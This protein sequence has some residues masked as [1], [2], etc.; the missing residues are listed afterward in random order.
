MLR[1]D[2]DPAD[3][4]PDVAEL[5]GIGI[6]VAV[7]LRLTAT[8]SPEN[9]RDAFWV[10]NVL[11]AN[12]P[13]PPEPVP[14][15]VLVHLDQLGPGARERAV[16]DVADIRAG[17]VP[18]RRRRRGEQAPAPPENRSRESPADADRSGCV[19]DPVCDLVP[20]L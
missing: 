6:G 7:A 4:H 16:L 2:V 8:E 1:R 14:L 12:A 19:D 9:L 18:G 5:P 11:V 3:D 13:W 10:L 15:I 20:C 17:R